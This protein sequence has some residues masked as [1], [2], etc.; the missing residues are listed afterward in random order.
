MDFKTNY[1]TI[2]FNKY[3][4]DG[5]S[6]FIGSLSGRS[7]LDTNNNITI[8]YHAMKTS[9]SSTK[10]III[11]SNA[12]SLS[13]QLHESVV[14][15]NNSGTNLN[16]RRNIVIG[17]ESLDQTALTNDVIA[18]GAHS[19]SNGS[20]SILIGNEIL[21]I[22][23][24]NMILGKSLQIIG[25][26]NIVLCTS[27]FARDMNNTILIGNESHTHVNIANVLQIHENTLYCDVDI[28]IDKSMEVNLTSLFR[29]SASFD[30]HVAFNDDIYIK[31]TWTISCH[32]DGALH[33]KSDKA[34][35]IFDEVFEAGVLNFTGQHRCMFKANG[36]DDDIIG[37]VVVCTGSYYNSDASKFPT[38]NESLPVV[39]LCSNKADKRVLGVVSSKCATFKI[40]NISFLQKFNDEVITVNSS[41]EGGM[42]VCDEN[43]PFEVGDLI[44][45]SNRVGYGCKQLDDILRNYTIGKITCSCDFQE[46]SVAF[47]GCIYTM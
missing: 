19:S 39:T 13:E 32:D 6:I 45:S 4:N 20:S 36:I 2:Q 10:N 21:T 16:G 8:G 35:V 43:G 27:S 1:A 7:L 30:D 26:N 12:S 34:Y 15:G 28:I 38:I 25:S 44:M 41:G 17:N 47:V 23:N 29:S 22:G 11:G 40:G 5:Y 42:W 46:S 24:E 3:N 9:S 18:I 31:S 37:K 33:F 14:I